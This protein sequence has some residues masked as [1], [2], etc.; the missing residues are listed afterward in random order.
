MS[1]L[2]CKTQ[3]RGDLLD[4]SKDKKHYHPSSNMM[5]EHCLEKNS[6]ADDRYR[7]PTQL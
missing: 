5:G 1:I 7:V 3:F 6:K 2:R 4:W